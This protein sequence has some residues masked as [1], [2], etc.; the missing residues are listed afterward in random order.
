MDN[1]IIDLIFTVLVF[2]AGYLWGKATAVRRIIESIARD[3]EHLGRA[4]DDY[5][6]IRNDTE[7]EGTDHEF[8]VEEHGGQIYVYDTESGE[9][10]AQAATLKSALE[11]VT[12]RFPDRKYQGAVTKEQAEELGIKS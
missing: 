4:L 10:L 11:L 9:F 1:F 5:R 8:R 12:Q 6:S 3:P 2:W 7:E